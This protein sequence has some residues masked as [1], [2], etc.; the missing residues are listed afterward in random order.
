MDNIEEVASY[1]VE[2]IDAIEDESIL[3]GAFTIPDDE[4]DPEEYEADLLEPD[5]E[6]EPFDIIGDPQN[7]NYP[8]EA[9]D[10]YFYSDEDEFLEDEQDELEDLIFEPEFDIED[11]ELELLEED[12]A[13]GEY[14]LPPEIIKNIDSL[15]S[16][17]E[18][19][20]VY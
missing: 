17:P 4:E 11:N 7:E 8:E 12:I 15:Y 19:R 6:E 3:L 13:D 1:L 18:D 14:D 16:W 20:Y 10:D 5:N 2:M 9:D